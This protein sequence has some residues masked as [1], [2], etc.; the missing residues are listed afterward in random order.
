MTQQSYSWVFILE[1][2]KIMFTQIPVHKCLLY[3]FIYNSPKL[4]KTQI[5]LNRWMDKEI[6][7]FISWNTARQ[8][9]NKL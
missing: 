4:E 9:R 7:T 5:Y 8:K 2:W 6:G 3:N 1:K